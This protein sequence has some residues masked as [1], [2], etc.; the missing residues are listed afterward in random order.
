M[1]FLTYNTLVLQKYSHGAKLS[2]FIVW[3]KYN[4]ITPIWVGG[5]V[6]GGGGGLLPAPD[7]SKLWPALLYTSHSTAVIFPSFVNPTWQYM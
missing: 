5:W 7:K 3:L 4:N 6:G 2:S 1:N